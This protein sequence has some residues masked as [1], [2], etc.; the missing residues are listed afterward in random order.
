[1]KSRPPL[2]RIVVLWASLTACA[3]VGFLFRAHGLPTDELVMANTWGFQAIAALLVIGL[4]SFFLL[5]AFLL[6]G[7]LIRCRQKATSPAL[8]RTTE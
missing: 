2:S 8:E 7:S 3:V 4:P 5:I 6:I 1:V